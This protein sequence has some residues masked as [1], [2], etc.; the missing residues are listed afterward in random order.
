MFRHITKRFY[1]ISQTL[2]V[3]D[4]DIV[5]ILQNPAKTVSRASMYD[6]RAKHLIKAIQS[7]QYDV[8]IDL[9]RKQNVPVDCH[10]TF[11]NTALTDAAAAGNNKGIAF[12]I[13]KLNAN[14]HASCD[15]HHH[16]TALHYA[17]EHGHIATVELLLKKGA[18]PNAL[19]SRKYTALDIATND[20]VKRILEQR[21]CLP[22]KNV[23]ETSALPR[24][25]NNNIGYLC[26]KS[27]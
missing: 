18:N 15:C 25:K 5:K 19:D 2:Y 1:S 3:S 23:N 24:N 17:S 20:E 16:K 11:E 21:G 13:D 9:V 7:E 22:G 6:P 26:S 14:V 10:T 8:A 4:K 27:K 12:L